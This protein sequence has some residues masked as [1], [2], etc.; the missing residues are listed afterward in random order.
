M[1]DPHEAR[2]LRRLI[3]KELQAMTVKELQQLLWKLQKR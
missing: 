3:C 2:N 1:S